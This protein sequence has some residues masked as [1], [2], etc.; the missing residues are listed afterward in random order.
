LK[1]LSYDEKLHKL[2]VN[3]HSSKRK[4]KDAATLNDFLSAAPNVIE[5]LTQGER[6]ASTEYELRAAAATAAFDKEFYGRN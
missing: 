5:R 1:N 2:I 6:K 3:V 4:V